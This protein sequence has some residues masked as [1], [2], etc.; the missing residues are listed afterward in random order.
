MSLFNCA[1]V[2]TGDWCRTHSLNWLTLS[3]ILSSAG[4]LGNG[5]VV[6]IH[7]K[8]V[9]SVASRASFGIYYLGR[10]LQWPPETLPGSIGSANGKRCTRPMGRR[11]DAWPNQIGFKLRH[12]AFV[13][14]AHHIPLSE[15]FLL[16]FF[17]QLLHLLGRCVG[18]S[19]SASAQK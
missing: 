5:P 3:I 4:A 19:Y 6:L 16:I 12:I 10:T 13:L 14:A 11:R 2:R 15:D 1:V 18:R 8:R 9:A 17:S 7:H